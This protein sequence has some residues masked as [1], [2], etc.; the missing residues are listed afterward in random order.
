MLYFIN[1]KYHYVLEKFL[2]IE[3]RII[4]ISL[5]VRKLINDRRSTRV[6][7]G[8]DWKNAAELLMCKNI[9]HVLCNI[10][11]GKVLVIVVRG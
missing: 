5:K 10:Q 1:R 8:N 4:L 3:T 2:K 6:G 9:Q 11:E 7:V